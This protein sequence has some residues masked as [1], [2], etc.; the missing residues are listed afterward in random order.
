MLQQSD[1]SA[2]RAAPEPGT[3][4]SLATGSGWLAARPRR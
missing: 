4:L 3:S 1:Q 2:D